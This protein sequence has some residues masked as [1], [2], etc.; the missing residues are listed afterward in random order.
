[1]HCLL[2]EYIGFIII[3]DHRIIKYIELEE[4]PKIFLLLFLVSLQLASY[5]ELKPLILQNET[6]D[7]SLFCF[8]PNQYLLANIFALMQTIKRHP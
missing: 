2:G 7:S 5:T 6:W 3:E 4:I 8:V 1:M